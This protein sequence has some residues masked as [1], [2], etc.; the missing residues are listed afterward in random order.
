M[1]HISLYKQFSQKFINDRFM[2]AHIPYRILIYEN[3]G[4][5]INYNTLFNNKSPNLCNC[6]LIVQL[7][8]QTKIFLVIKQSLLFI[9]KLQVC[10]C[11]WAIR[12]G[13]TYEACVAITRNEN[14]VQA[15]NR[16]G[17]FQTRFG[18]VANLLCIHASDIIQ[19]SYTFSLFPFFL[20]KYIIDIN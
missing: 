13:Y 15:M 8:F 10:L 17:R 14:W 19:G 6:L 7:S 1:F 11:R 20:Y 5:N 4:Y 18:L 16:P 2:F 9:D 3:S 12:V